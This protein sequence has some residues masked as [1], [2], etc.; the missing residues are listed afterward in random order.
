MAA[1][2]LT[3]AYEATR[4]KAKPTLSRLHWLEVR[5]G[6]DVMDKSG[7]WEVSDIS[8]AHAVHSS[9]F[10]FQRSLAVV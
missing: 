7:L 1:G 5:T 9:V 6:F 4:F 10:H 8:T 3:G 2:L